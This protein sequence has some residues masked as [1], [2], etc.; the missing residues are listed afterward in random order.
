MPERSPWKPDRPLFIGLAGGSGSG[1]TTIAEAVLERLD[2]KVALVQHDA[3]YRHMPEY[4]Y[5]ERTKVNYDH[6]ASLETE[7]LVQHLLALRS[8]EP[9]ERPVYDFAVHLRSDDTV[10]VEPAQVVVVEGILVLA[11]PELRSELD[12]KIFVDTDSDI[13]LA[14]RLQRDI[15]ERG[16]TVESVVSQ[17]FETVRPMH[18][19][20][21]ETSK[22]YADLIIPEGYN[23]RAVATVV[24]LIRSRLG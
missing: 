22:R 17:Y 13:R 23:P 19:Q 8:G 3:Y 18:V 9:I 16:R 2:G 10:R 14:R 24:E 6:P 11:E 20:Y 5:E 4:S 7:L 1:K 12:L 15:E 21:V